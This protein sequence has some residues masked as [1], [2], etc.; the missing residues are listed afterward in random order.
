MESKFLA[1]IEEIDACRQSGFVRMALHVALSLPDICCEAENVGKK[2][3]DKDSDCSASEGGRGARY[4]EWWN[5]HSKHF[6]H[7]DPLLDGKRLYQLRNNFFHGAN[8]HVQWKDGVPVMIDI[9]SAATCKFPPNIKYCTLPHS[10]INAGVLIMEVINVARQFYFKSSVSIK[11]FLDGFERFAIA[12]HED[13][14]FANDRIQRHDCDKRVSVPHG[15]EGELQWLQAL[16]TGHYCQQKGT[17]ALSLL[18]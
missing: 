13:Y 17:V 12:S 18:Y 5:R 3:P 11:V 15:Q 6:L 4:K 10:P 9:S 1:L 8:M 16:T 14:L 2:E 7:R